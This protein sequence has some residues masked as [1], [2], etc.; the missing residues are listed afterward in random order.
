M[1]DI[2]MHQ[3]V[4]NLPLLREHNRLGE[5]PVL[6]R[7]CDHGDSGRLVDADLR[8][9]FKNRKRTQAH[10]VTKGQAEIKTESLVSLGLTAHVASW[11]L[12][13]KNKAEVIARFSGGAHQLPP[14]R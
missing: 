12:V 13:D 8:T 4:D 11:V 14:W 1:H 5:R 3:L 10:A 9:G 6:R 2:A 7:A